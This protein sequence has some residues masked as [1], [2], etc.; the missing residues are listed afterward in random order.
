VVAGLVIGPVLLAAGVL[1]FPSATN[2]VP[3]N[4][5]PG[6][7]CAPSTGQARGQLMDG[8][9]RIALS[10]DGNQHDEDDWAGAAMGLA[11]L[12]HRNLQPNVVHYDYDN[13]IWDSEEQYRENMRDSVLEGGERL[14]FDTS[15]FY[16]ATVPE[17]LDAGVRNLTAEINASTADDELWI[18][19]AGP[20]E[21]AWM[22]LDAADP[23]ARQHVKCLSH[24]EW[25]ETH[26]R[27]DHGGHDYDDLIDLGCQEV[28]IP[29][30]NHNLG[31]TDMSDWDY[32]NDLGDDM[33]W[34]Y[35]RIDLL[36]NGD[37]S[38]A[39]MDYYIITGNEEVS[40]SELRDF[41]QS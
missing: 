11:L 23:D 36:G 4:A 40:R 34:L 29:D 24:G 31:E 30:Q 5:G 14:G 26:G 9:G 2:P 16:D 41:L 21:T 35:E 12:A 6:T 20:M 7:P 27:D 38:D 17:E 33:Q 25:N 32:L 1:L 15:R 37:V 13:H 39:G 3:G 22:A 10:S 8:S 19:L 18:V 28:R